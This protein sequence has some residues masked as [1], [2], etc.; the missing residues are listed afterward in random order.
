[1][2]TTIETEV[3]EQKEQVHTLDNIIPSRFGISECGVFRETG[4]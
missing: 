1:M 4:L 2:I 3:S